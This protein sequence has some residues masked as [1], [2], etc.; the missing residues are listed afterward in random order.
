[1]THKNINISLLVVT[2]LTIF[3]FVFGSIDD[4]KYDIRLDSL[5][6][7]VNGGLQTGLIVVLSI[8][9]ATK[10]IKTENENSLEKIK[11]VDQNQD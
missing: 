1:M 6:I 4:S 5:L 8:L 2:I 10:T 11:I 7:I 3:I 9:L